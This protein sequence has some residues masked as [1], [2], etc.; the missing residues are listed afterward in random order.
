MLQQITYTHTHTH[1][2]LPM[3]DVVGQMHE[4]ESREEQSGNDLES[5]LYRRH[6]HNHTLRE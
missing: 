4:V 6:S 5:S 2:H 1:T 3:E